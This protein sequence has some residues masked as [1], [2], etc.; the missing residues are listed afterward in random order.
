M[1]RSHDAGDT[2]SVFT[3]AGMFTPTVHTH[4]PWKSTTIRDCLAMV[5]Y[6]NS[7]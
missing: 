2:H 5:Y 1:R 7:E 4:V 3:E 6:K